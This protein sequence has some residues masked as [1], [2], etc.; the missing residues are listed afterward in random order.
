MNFL[1][2]A[3]RKFRSKTGLYDLRAELAKW[4]EKNLGKEYVDEALDSY[5][6]I[7]SGVPMGGFV[8]T[9]AFL[10]LVERVKSDFAEA[11]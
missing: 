4:V 9:A 10:D 1:S 3:F 5:D 11:K 7:Q 2:K 8:E 6:K